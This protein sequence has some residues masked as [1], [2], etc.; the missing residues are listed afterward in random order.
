M[1]CKVFEKTCVV[2]AAAA[3]LMLVVGYATVNAQDAASFFEGN[4][5]NFMV[6]YSP[7]G[8][9]DTYSRLVASTMERYAKCTVVVRNMPG[10]GGLVALNYMYNT[11]KRDGRAMM[12][13]PIGSQIA[14]L[15]GSPGVKYDCRQFN[16]LIRL[17]WEPQVV[18]VSRESPYKSFDDLRKPKK[19]LSPQTEVTGTSCLA[20][21]ATAEALGLD[22]LKIVPGRPGST[23]C[24]LAIVR[25]EG[26]VYSP[27][28][29]TVLQH[30]EELRPLLVVGRERVPELPD[31]PTVY[32]LGPKKDSERFLEIFVAAWEIGRSIFAPQD[33]PQERVKF[34]RETLMKCLQDKEFLEKT[35]KLKRSIDPM[36]GEEVEVL[37]KKVMGL[38]AED[39][40]ALKHIVFEKYL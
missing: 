5:V 40:K 35:E 15:M 13:A 19:L 26:E 20:A 37:V 11:A 12:I 2:V 39:I 8:G 25:G 14:Q 23:E 7:G 32:E 28:L 38:S 16:W 34:L 6:G 24:V 18:V 1:R 27:S 22:N 29:G 3:M 21:L 30:K 17:T 9:Y 4:V 10:A 33:V 31:V 36:P